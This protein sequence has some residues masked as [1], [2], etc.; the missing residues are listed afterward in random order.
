LSGARVSLVADTAGRFDLTDDAAAATGNAPSQRFGIIDIG[1]NSVRLVVYAGRGRN[2]ISVFN[3]KV[4]AGLGRSVSSTGRLSADGMERAFAALRRFNALKD[5][6][7]IE[8]FQAVATAAVR[9]AEDGPDFLRHAEQ[10]CGQPIRLLSGADEARYAA[11]GVICGFPKASGIVGDLG[12]GS[13]ELVPVENGEIVG[14]GATTGLGPL[15][16]MDQSG[17]SLKTARQIVEKTLEGQTWLKAHRGKPLYAVGGTWRNL[18]RIHMAQSDYPIHVLHNYVIPAGD[19]SE[20]AHLISQLGPKSLAQI[21]D[22][23]ERRVE[24]LPYGAVALEKLIE[25]MGASEVIISAYGLREGLLYDTLDPADRAQDPLI[26]GARDMARRLS[27]HPQ[28]GDEFADW[29]APLFRQGEVAETEDEARLRHAACL[30]ADIGWYVHPDHRAYHCLSEILYAPFSGVDHEGRLYLARAIYHRHEG[31]G[32]P[33]SLERASMMLPDTL[34]QRALVLGLALRLAFTMSGATPGILLQTRLSVDTETLR[35][36][37][38]R[39]LAALLGETVSKRL[40]VL[41][42]ALE[43]QA[44]IRVVD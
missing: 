16:L 10:V 23:S 22:V 40:N 14:E 41:A 36:E 9:D 21:P 25:V 3:E 11:Y 35:L 33:P 1:S 39:P 19:A 28:M 38:P 20:L 13:L 37:V 6:I 12:G 30:L 43:R 2:P 27:R 34:N 42:K 24:A 7:G 5:L 31:K 18:A 8:S 32:E 4:M 29:T 15:R 44:D 17:E 26:A